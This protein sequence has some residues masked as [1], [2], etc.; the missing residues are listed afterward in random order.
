MKQTIIILSILL[1]ACIILPAQEV[2]DEDFLD[3][4]E[5]NANALWDNTPAAFKVN[6]I[7]EKYKKESAVIFGFKRELS[8]D[9]KSKIGFLTK[10]EKALYFYENVRF[11]IKLLD[12]NAVNSFTEFYFRYSDKQDGFSAKIYKVDGSVNKVNLADAVKME[13]NNSIPE[14]FKSF[15]DQE[16]INRSRYF[17]VALPDL[18]PGDIL[19]YLAISRSKL[20][21]SGSGIVSFSPQYELCAKLYPILFNQIAIE[22]DEKSY[23]KA[24]SKN[25]APEFKKEAAQNE[26]FARFVF[27]DVNRVPNKDVSFLNT[28]K[29]L[30]FTKFQIIYSNK[31]DPKG[32]LMGQQGEV[33][34]NFTKEQLALEAW[35]DYEKTGDF[36]FSDYFTIDAFVAA[37][38]KQL[39][40]YGA[41]EWD[42]KEY[43][44]NAFY[45]VRSYVAYQDK[46]LP[47]QY[48]A[49]IFGS[50]LFQK[51]IKSELIIA[52]SNDIGNMN[53]VLFDSEL[54]YVTKVGK[55]YYYNFTDHCNPGELRSYLLNTTGYLIDEPAKKTKEQNIKPIVLPNTTFEQNTAKYQL[56]VEIN[57]DSSYL[58]VAKT[59]TYIGLSKSR[60][61]DDALRYTPYLLDDWKN[62]GGESPTSKMNSTQEDSYL[63]ATRETKKEYAKEKPIFVK[64]E[65]QAEYGSKVV[66][67]DFKL[68]SD[69]RSLK[70]NTLIFTEE[71][72]LYG[73]VR[74]A[75]KKILVN[76]P[77][78]I[79]SQLQLKKEERL[80]NNDID[81]DFARSLE[82]EIKF[83]V[84]VNYTVAGLTE[85]NN[86]INNNIGQYECVAKEE[87]GIVTISVKKVYKEAVFAKDKWNDMLAFIDAAFNT[88]YKYIL[89]TPKN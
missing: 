19:E 21:V 31:P 80:R 89:L 57:I 23:F 61:I 75:G 55:D 25:G 59:N 46:Y 82:W 47:E 4:I 86:S 79:G 12:K 29:S 40:K 26:D 36:Y 27:T 51:E 33:K 52:V 73:K 18:E 49:Y 84:P 72:L 53:D 6:D 8:I 71:F 64:K 3:K 1:N 22:T 48:A 87:A 41:K 15:F 9:K 32:I 7:D 65:L 10:G 20:D 54:K 45:F 24:M 88:S 14:F 2:I 50:L 16:T 34:N 83:K 58:T 38:W 60:N 81:L 35:Q 63:E 70:K 37:A 39:V 5:I 74:K 77:G 43:I 56:N 42:D 62:Y 28:Y 66:Y 69:G 44:K 17:K 68:E 76:I 13:S 11:K 85:L 67:K 78:L 30:P